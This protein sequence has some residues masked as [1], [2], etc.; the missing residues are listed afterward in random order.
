MA[1]TVVEMMN[2]GLESTIPIA[3]RMGLRVVEARRGFA[4]AS[5]PAEGNGNHFGV[6]YAG[7]QFTVAEIL[8]GIIALTSFDASKYYP[9]VKNVD[10][11][12][13]GMA[14]SELRAEAT[15]DDETI[16]RVEA[17]AADRGKADYTLDAVVT[18]A[19]GNV[20][21]TTHGLYQLRAQRN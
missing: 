15:I 5:V 2:A 4:A 17:E 12:F 16:A 19:A 18:D 6:I 10:I 20:V 21:A 11:K 1:D 13:V 8:G 14:T 7:V 9:L 3:A